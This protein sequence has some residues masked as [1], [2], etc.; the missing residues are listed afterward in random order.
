MRPCVNDS[1]LVI[2]TRPVWLPAGNRYH[3][4]DC[5]TGIHEYW[6]HHTGYTAYGRATAIPQHGGDA[7]VMTLS[8]EFQ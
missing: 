4:V 7:L 1:S 2:I 5:S 8:I 3:K 6:P